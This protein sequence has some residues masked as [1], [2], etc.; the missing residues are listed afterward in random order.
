[1]NYNELA[2]RAHSNAVEHGFWNDKLSNEHCLMLIIT[3]I[4]EM[5]EADRNNHMADVKQYKEDANPTGYFSRFG[6]KG[7]KEAFEN[8]I[9]N[10][11]EDEFA[12][13]AIR[14]CDISGA[15]G[16]D[17]D[18]MQPC[19]YYRAYDRFSFTENA[20]ALCK[21]LSKENIAI[22]KRI[23]FGLQYIENWAK[24]L[25]VDIDTFISMKMTYNIS[26]Q[27]KHGKKY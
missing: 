3:E 7:F 5:V 8:N 2:Q 6:K 20:F 1:M 14:L 10:S 9:K 18:K 12:D 15:L 26:R 22:A 13:V 17:F 24:A 25:D 19:R 4:A 27:A 21:G 23:Q 16:I 11:L